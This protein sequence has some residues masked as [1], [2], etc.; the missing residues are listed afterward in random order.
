MT[1][2]FKRIIQIKKN[3]IYKFKTVFLINEISNDN[4]LYQYTPYFSKRND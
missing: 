2:I 4:L 3:E 1:L